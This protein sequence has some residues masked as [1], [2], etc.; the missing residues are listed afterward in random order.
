MSYQIVSD[1]LAHELLNILDHRQL[2]PFYQPIISF[3]EQH[4]MGYECLIR[5]PTNSPLHSPFILFHVAHECG[6]LLE[7]ELLASQYAIRNF[8]QLKLEGKLFINVSLPALLDPRF[9]LPHLPSLLNN[10]II[11]ISGKHRS[12]QLKATCDA[13][14]NYRLKGCQIAIDDLGIGYADLRL[15]A[16]L[17]PHYIKIDKYFFQNLHAHL[18]KKEFIRTLRDLAMR[19]NCQIIAEGIENKKDYQEALALGVHLGQGYYFAYPHPTPP[20]KLPPELF[21]NEEE[22]TYKKYFSQRRSNTIASLIIDVPIAYPSMTVEKVADVFHSRPDIY[23]IPVI[24]SS[25]VAIGMVRRHNFMHLLL[26]RYGRELHGRKPISQFMDIHHTVL[27]ITASLEEASQQLT[28]LKLNIEHDFIISNQGKYCGLGR[29]VDLLEKMTEL[30]IRNARYANPLTL[31]PGNV[32]IYEHI[33]ELLRQHIPF[34]IAYGDLD[35]FKP[36]NDV[37]G[38]DKGDLVIQTLAKILITH[39][40][41]IKD[42]VGHIGGDDFILVMQSQDWKSRCE[43]ILKEFE[44]TVLSFYNEL[45]RRNGGIQTLDRMGHETFFPL[46]SLSIGVATPDL[47]RCHSHHDVAALASEAKHEAKRSHGNTLLVFPQKIPHYQTF[48]REKKSFVGKKLN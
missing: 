9:Q 36:F 29:V 33:E 10:L 46:L 1:E 35:H 12:E 14:Q 47:E 39:T 26:N 45:D 27:D 2:F 34:S 25:H 32:P 5:G 48:S 13:V 6:R 43:K 23:S 7:L 22:Q 38:Y 30:Q 20:Q 3:T 4:I 24:N 16:E 21:L 41:P 44:Q 42:F 19:L 17:R 40:D 15:W 18:G 28:G 37:Y 31:L 11:E 8:Q